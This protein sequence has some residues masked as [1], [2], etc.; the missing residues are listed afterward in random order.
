MVFFSLLLL[1]LVLL[2]IGRGTVDA[3]EYEKH[4]CKSWI[5]S[6]LGADVAATSGSLSKSEFLTFTQTITNPPYIGAYFNQFD[7]YD[8]L[9][10]S[11]K[12]ICKILT[13][14]CEGLGYGNT[15]CEGPTAEL[16]LDGL[17][18]NEETAYR[19][20]FC[21]MIALVVS[22]VPIPNPTNKP[23]IELTSGPVTSAPTLAP[24]TY[25]PITG[26]PFKHYRLFPPKLSKTS[27]G[28]KSGKAS[29]SGKLGNVSAIISLSPTLTPVTAQPQLPT[30]TWYETSQLVETSCPNMCAPHVAIDGDTAVFFGENDAIQFLTYDDVKGEFVTVTKLAANYAASAV[31]V[32][33]N[34]TV[35][36]DDT[37]GK[38][39]VYERDDTGQWSKQPD[40]PIPP[41]VTDGSRFGSAVAID[42]VVVAAGA[43]Q[44]RNGTGAVYVYRR[45]GGEWVREATLLAVDPHESPFEEFGNSIS[46]QG[47]LI[48]LGD[49][50]HGDFNQGGV[51][52]YEYQPTRQNW[53]MV[54]DPIT[55]SD[56]ELGYFGS[57]L[58]LLGD[59]GFMTTCSR[60]N[61]KR[62]AIYY[63]T[64]DAETGLYFLAQKIVA[65]GLAPG[66]EFGGGVYGEIDASENLM[67]TGIVSGNL[68]SIFTVLNGKWVEVDKIDASE[69]S[70]TSATEDGYIF[71]PGNREIVTYGNKIIVAGATNAYVYT[72]LII[73]D[74][75]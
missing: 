14:Q 38:V 41:D 6:A 9:P 16:P 55:N 28:A 13:C 43:T 60:E 50:Y 58:V 70:G 40:L 61:D 44:A 37:N 5:A 73:D 1:L 65:S 59:G 75:G 25:A 22:D 30:S 74:E 64:R 51:H 68:V 32:S 26:A 36:G 23:T 47:D 24:T 45:S 49:M 66:D 35:I 56:C 18:T 31:S 20:Y 12:L 21:D 52:I 53:T 17:I 71:L 34:T 69:L 67:A 2:P 72:L 27:K 62:G 10:Y 19:N 54:G 33:G 4:E 57:G 39:H 46:L 7:T 3:I 8:D 63:Y 29:K 48:A 42:G 15:C 11:V